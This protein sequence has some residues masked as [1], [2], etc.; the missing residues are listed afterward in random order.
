[1]TD[2]PNDLLDL[3]TALIE[4]KQPRWLMG[5][6][7]ICR[8]TDERTVIASVFPKVGVG[9]TMPIFHLNVNPALSAAS[10]A[11][12][13]SL[14]FDFI[15]R[16]SIGGT[17]LTYSYLKQFAVLPPST[18][19][20]ADLTFI[21]PR[22]LELTYTSHS[23]RPWA[24]DLGYAGAPFAWDEDRRAV[25]RSE[26]DAFFAR[27]YGLTRDELR[28]ILDP[29]DAKGAD[30]PS[31]TFR[32]LKNK[33]EARYNEYRT[34][35]MVLEAWDRLAETRHWRATRRVACSS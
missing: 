15:A 13:T 11:M 20:P 16:L 5:W 1:M 12:W 32:V 33:E 35:R 24:E 34:G 2:G 7:D 21:T 31:E 9:H 27:K 25:L 19:T 28:Y 23:M 18:F 30:Y 26:L 22:V 4:R 8:S 17:H 29:A 3:A 6:R 10:L 14:S